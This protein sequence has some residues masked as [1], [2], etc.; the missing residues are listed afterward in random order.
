[1]LCHAPHIGEEKPA[2][3]RIALSV[4][5]DGVADVEGEVG[6]TGSKD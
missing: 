5:Q 6:S 4:P 3:E 1:M 2:Q